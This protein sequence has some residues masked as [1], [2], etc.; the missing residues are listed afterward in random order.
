MARQGWKDARAHRHA[1]C[2]MPHQWRQ[3][4]N[5]GGT[6]LWLGVRCL[7]LRQHFIKALALPSGGALLGCA[8]LRRSRRLAGRGQQ[9]GERQQPEGRHAAYIPAQMQLV[10]EP[11]WMCAAI[12]PLH[13]QVAGRRVKRALWQ[14]LQWLKVNLMCAHVTR[15]ESRQQGPAGRQLYRPAGSSWVVGSS[16]RAGQGAGHRCRGSAQGTRKGML[17]I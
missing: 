15:R 10:R 1:G 6:H 4:R 9:Q 11:R 5:P 17:E 12:V 7:D 3:R 16:L 2:R 13:S 8:L 14:L